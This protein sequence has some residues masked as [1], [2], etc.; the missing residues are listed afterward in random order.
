MQVVDPAIEG[1]IG[2][3]IEHTSGAALIV[4]STEAERRGG[5]RCVR[6]VGFDGTHFEIDIADDH[7]TVS[8]RA[9]VPTPILGGQRAASATRAP[10]LEKQLGAVRVTGDETT[11][12]ISVDE[13]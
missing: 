3:R 9:T 12:P 7:E 1:G 11:M 6:I 4:P 13:D 10:Q 5:V 8:I 2:V